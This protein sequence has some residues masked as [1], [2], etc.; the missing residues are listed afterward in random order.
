MQDSLDNTLMRRWEQ[1]SSDVKSL[2]RGNARALG[3][4]DTPEVPGAYVLFDEYM[5]ILYVG[6][7]GNLRDRLLSKHVSGDESHAL[8][9]A[10]ANRF[11][12]RAERRQFIRQNVRAKWLVVR[13]P[14]R[15]ADL[16]RLLIWLLQPA[17][18][19]G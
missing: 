18:N 4:A 5:T 12:D 14:A 2:M 17:L 15:L 6:I 11:R 16:E 19:R 7:A 10:Y 9:R 1:F 3:A 13:D 8:Q